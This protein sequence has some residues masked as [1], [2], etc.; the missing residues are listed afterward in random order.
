MYIFV[1]QRTFLILLLASKDVEF[2]YRRVLKG[3]E[4]WDK[5]MNIFDDFSQGKRIV[6]SKVYSIYNPTLVSAFITQV[7]D[8][9]FFLKAVFLF[10]K[11]P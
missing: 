8:F 3:S 11:S 9:H 6:V 2:Y 5:F 10:E 4:C 7:Y 1:V